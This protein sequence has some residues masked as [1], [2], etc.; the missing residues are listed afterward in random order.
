MMNRERMTEPLYVR[1]SDH[2]L[3]ERL[4][5]AQ[6]ILLVAHIRPDGDSIGSLL[7]LGLALQAAGKHVEMVSPDGVPSTY[8]HLD[9]SQ[10]IVR[11]PVNGWDYSISLDCSDLGRTGGVFPVGEK[12]DLNIDHH[13]TNEN[14]AR[15]NLVDA[16]ATATA[17]ILAELIP[18]LDLPMTQAS[19]EAL[20]TGLVTDTIGFRTSN[21]TPRALRVAASLMEEGADLSELYRQ[22]LVQRSFEAVRYWTQGL[23]KMERAGR[24]A[25][26]TLTL[27]DRKAANYPG[28][29]DADLINVLA[30]MNEIDIAIVFVEQ[31]KGLV[32]VS[33]RAAPGVD[34][35][36]LARGFG[37]G[38]HPAAAGAE[39]S[40]SLERVTEIVLNQTQALLDEISMERQQPAA[41]V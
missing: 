38:G 29:D 41:A 20:L 7:G 25:W 36:Q 10:G 34:V 11:K 12:P 30:S 6:H 35:S 39:M 21:M 15:V 19:A 1:V 40:G 2:G 9:G 33:W 18:L 26:T 16:Q 4:Q 32:K 5:A 31:G 17:E 8:Q 37:G 3:G 24:L 13:I 28:R 23:V 22:S 14:F 27:A